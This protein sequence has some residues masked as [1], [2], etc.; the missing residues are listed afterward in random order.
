MS[1]TLPTAAVTSMADQV[2]SAVITQLERLRF[3]R[4]HI[5]NDLALGVD[6]RIP[7]RKALVVIARVARG[8]GLSSN[9]I[10]KSDLKPEQVTSVSN[11][12]DLLTRRI[13]DAL[14]PL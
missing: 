6:P 12:I 3:D 1:S 7:S 2:R 8:F 5:E 14:E 10:R 13:S 9:V 4:T 11:L